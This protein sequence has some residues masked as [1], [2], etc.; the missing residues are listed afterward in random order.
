MAISRT[1]TPSQ[2]GCVKP[3]GA[4]ASQRWTVLRTA[5]STIARAKSSARITWPR[6]ASCL[7]PNQIVNLARARGFELGG[8]LVGFRL[9]PGSH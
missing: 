2:P 3:I 8:S 4:A 5:T 1:L 7:L 6:K 9:G